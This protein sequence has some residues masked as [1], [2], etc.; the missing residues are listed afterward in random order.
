M[1][2]KYFFVKLSDLAREQT[3]RSDVDFVQSFITNRPV[4]YYPFSQIFEMVERD[5]VDVKELDDFSYC[6]IGDVDSNGE[7]YPILLNINNR[8]ELNESYFKKIEKGDIRSVRVGDILITSVRPNLRK[9]VYIDSL[10]SDIFFTKA[11]LHL[12]P[13]VNSKLVFY[14]LRS[15]F[16]DNVIALSRQGKGYP[17][18][19]KEDLLSLCLDKVLIDALMNQQEVIQEKLTALEA[20]IQGEKAKLVEPSAIINAVFAREFQVDLDFVRKYQ[21]APFFNKQFSEFA[22]GNGDL[23]MS[24]RWFKYQELK[25]VLHRNVTCLKKLGNYIIQS[26]NGWSPQCGE[27]QSELAVLGIDS[28]KNSQIVFDNLKFTDQLKPNLDQLF[29]K[30]GDFLISRG[31]TVDLVALAGIVVDEPE[32]DT[33]YPDLMIRIEFTEE[34]N[35][36]YMAYVFNSFFGRYYFKYV[37]KGKNQTMVKVSAT[38]L[39]MF[40][41]PLPDL[42][43]QNRIVDEIEIS[44]NAEQVS[45]TAIN[46]KW[47]EIDDLFFNSVGVKANG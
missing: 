9:F 15:I 29:I 27:H 16:F 26:R 33:I 13:L 25:V 5:S 43:T 28:I 6:E 18:L 34:V 14:A 10:K 36:K 2:L 8:N 3:L 46:R 19:K 20:E 22:A 41:V 7:V 30:K 23:R 1:E 39:L 32:T 42:A 11:F 12:R 35:K 44:L 38:E 21:S 45:R 24:Y 4:S 47:I 37:T 40:D 31:N 17:T